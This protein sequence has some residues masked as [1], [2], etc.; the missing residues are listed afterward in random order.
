MYYIVISI[1]F[2]IFKTK[3]IIASLKFTISLL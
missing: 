1:L 3:I 2:I